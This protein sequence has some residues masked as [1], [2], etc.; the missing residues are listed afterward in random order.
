MI[1][2]PMQCGN[3]HAYDAWFRSSDA[4]AKLRDGGHLCCEVC[5]SKQVSK[6]ITAP[7]IG[8]GGDE[9]SQTEVP[10]D[11][12]LEIVPAWL[13]AEDV[14]NRFAQVVRDM[15]SGQEEPRTVRGVATT[16]EI[17]SLTEDG[18]PIRPIQPVSEVN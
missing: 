8:K 17:R 6:A 10:A 9:P 11:A 13:K 1:K 7:R 14:G 15:H 4:F 3:G 5:G 16:E 12:A 18:Y 2:Y